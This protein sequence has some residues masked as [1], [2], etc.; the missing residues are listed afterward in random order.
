MFNSEKGQET[1]KP[2]KMFMEGHVCAGNGSDLPGIP[3]ALWPVIMSSWWKYHDILQTHQ[4][5][6]SGK[7][8]ESRRC[9]LDPFLA[10]LHLYHRVLVAESDRFSALFKKKPT[11]TP[12]KNPTK[13]KHCLDIACYHW[14]SLVI[15][16]DSLVTCSITHI[17]KRWQDFIV[18]ELKYKLALRARKA[19]L[20]SR[21]DRN[22]AR[23]CR[24]FK[25]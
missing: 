18:P 4:F 1:S 19:V 23:A 11:K 16:H 3:P 5:R 13:T 2:L 21:Y 6:P 20:H 15:F 22:S 14:I 17:F 7:L 9:A 12:T 25:V 8:R 10:P 24:F